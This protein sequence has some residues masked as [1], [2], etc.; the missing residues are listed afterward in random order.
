MHLFRFVMRS[1]CSCFNILTSFFSEAKCK[2]CQPKKKYKGMFYY[3]LE[4]HMQKF[5]HFWREK[6]LPEKVTY[7]RLAPSHSIKETLKLNSKKCKWWI[8]VVKGNKKH[9]IIF[10][11]SLILFVLHSDCYT[12]WVLPTYKIYID[13]AWPN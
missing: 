3:S 4:K 12:L 13:L 11:S 1:W 10:C 9:K 7:A 6:I 8:F 5:R 2:P